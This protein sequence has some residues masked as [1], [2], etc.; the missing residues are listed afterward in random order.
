MSNWDRIQVGGGGRGGGG[1][2]SQTRLSQMKKILQMVSFDNVYGHL[3]L[4]NYGSSKF[5]NW[6]LDA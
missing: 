6:D 2:P 3:H 4:L 1:Q 5:V